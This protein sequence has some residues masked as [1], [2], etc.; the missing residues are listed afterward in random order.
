[1]SHQHTGA[2]AAHRSRLTLVFGLTALYFVAEVVGALLTNSLALLADAAH[3]L[4]DVAGLGL[5]LFAIW[6]AARP[7]HPGK[8][9][10]YYRIEILAALLNGVVLLAVG[11]YILW[12]A[13]E[14]F[15]EPPEVSGG[16]MVVV[17]AF[18]LAVNI[19]GV[20]LL[21]RGAEESLNVQGA[22]LE[23]VADLL[24]SLGVLIAGSIIWATGWGYADP[25]FS[26]GIGIFV[27]P[28]TLR[29]MSR[30]VHVLMEGAPTDLD[31][32]EV[33]R[34]MMNV[35][36]VQT[37]HDLHVWS[38]TSGV[39]SLSAH[40]RIDDIAKGDDVLELL[41]Q[42]LARR[43]N[44]HHTTIQIE[45]SERAEVIY[46]QSEEHNE[47]PKAEQSTTNHE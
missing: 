8:S 5:A 1:M 34:V 3:M 10:G 45:R 37:I 11:V 15:R 27:V 32:A 13:W 21:R 16:A 26:I 20:V 43:F 6:F 38:I 35:S 30:A 40:A 41:G 28:R 24:G 7:A 31:V 23:V 29:L 42:E 9:Y 2:G 14:R 19:V 22:F 46:H 44:I 33:E 39:V 18:G 36:G 17:A 25:I 47:H 12:E 4:T